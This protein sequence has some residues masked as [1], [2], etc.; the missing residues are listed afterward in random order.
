MSAV[1]PVFPDSFKHVTMGGHALD[2]TKVHVMGVLNVTPDSFSD[3]G[4]FNTFDAALKQ[5]EAMLVAGAAIID[6][7]GESTRPGAKSVSSNEEIARVCPVVE[8]LVN[9]LGACVSVDTSNPVLMR[10][11]VAL[12]AGL[13][14]DVRGFRR[15]G[16]V[17][18]IA[19]SEGVALCVMHMQGE[20]DTMQQNPS[21]AELMGDVSAFLQARCEV[22]QQA[23]VD[24]GRII[25]DPGFGF[26]KTL[27][28]NL[29]M[30]H[31]FDEFLSLGYPLLAGVSRKSMFGALLDKPVDQRMVASVV[32][33]SLAAQKG[34]SILRVHDVNE[35]MDAA[36]L[37]NAL[38]QLE[39]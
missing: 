11:A 12:G 25:L 34:A 24:A 4:R 19:E 9:K 21:Y 29:L 17:A 13:I 8:A 28:H 23:G 2:L 1:N 20:P 6:V 36:K 26:G 30:L 27:E 14:N 5:A 7:G 32:G 31:R 10:E 35:T 15:E 33:A 3:G 16:A 38:R 18:A 22:L 39:D 37:I